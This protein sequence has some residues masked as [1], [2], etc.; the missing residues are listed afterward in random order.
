MIISIAC[1]NNSLSMDNFIKWKQNFNEIKSIHDEEICKVRDLIQY[2]KNLFICGDIGVGKTFILNRLVDEYYGIDISHIKNINLIED[3]NSFV[4]IDPYEMKYKSFIELVSLKKIILKKSLVVVSDKVFV[5]DNF[6]TIIIH[7]KDPE[8]IKNLSDSNNSIESAKKCM[9]NLHNFFH[10]LENSDQKDEFKTSSDILEDIFTYKT[11][12]NIENISEHGH[13]WDMLHSNYI[14]SSGCDIDIIS[15]SMSL[16]DIWDTKI[17]N[18]DW[19]YIP[20]FINDALNIPYKN[21]GNS[22]PKEKLKPGS[23]W[24]KFGNYKMRFHKIKEIKYRSTHKP[25]ID[26]L[27]LILKRADKGD[28]SILEEYKINKSHLDVI[29]HLCINNKLKS[30]KLSSI[31]KYV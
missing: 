8:I 3:I 21:M 11:Y 31:K 24:T 15:E 19:D 22:I 10:Y 26:E 7:K 23:S 1:S 12:S 20:Y 27:C 16:A 2:N 18:N 25:D 28:S 6:E 29:N 5:L 4:Y 30:N 17:Y 9:G 13:L 14:N